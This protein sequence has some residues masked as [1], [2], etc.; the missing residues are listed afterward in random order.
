VSETTACASSMPFPGTARAIQNACSPCPSITDAYAG[1]GGSTAAA[2]AGGAARG[3]SGTVIPRVC[4][5]WR[6][7]FAS[8]ATSFAA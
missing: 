6:A 4:R 8:F 5:M 1:G 3:G 2:G 7:R